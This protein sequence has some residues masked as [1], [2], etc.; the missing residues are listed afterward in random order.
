MVKEKNRA[1]G[2][3]TRESYE[4]NGAMQGCTLQIDYRLKCSIKSQ[5][6]KSTFQEEMF[7]IV[8]DPLKNSPLFL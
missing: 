4:E 1:K 7:Q 5:N 3:G 6:L 8:S 2:R